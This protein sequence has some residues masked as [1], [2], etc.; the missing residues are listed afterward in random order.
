MHDVLL[1]LGYSTDPS[2]P[3][4][5]SRVETAVTHYIEGLAPQ[6]IMSG[7]CSMSLDR[8]PSVTEAAVMRDYAIDLGVPS[9]AILL[10][11]DSVDT[12]GNFYFSK[13]RFLEPC[14]WYHVG[15][16]TTPWHAFRSEWLAAQILGPDYAFEMVLAPNPADWNEA[17]IRKSELRNRSLL[18]ETQAQLSDMAPGDHEA[19]VP[20][21]GKAPPS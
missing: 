18:A 15:V 9:S 19:I 17:D 12:I 1:V 20:F 2:H 5:R 14:A 21:L 11:E 3:V 10:E 4:F 8:K 6:I 16:V 7:C 13:K